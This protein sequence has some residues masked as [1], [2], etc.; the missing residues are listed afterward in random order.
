MLALLSFN[1]AEFHI[2]VISAT[3]RISFSSAPLGEDHKIYFE[4]SVQC[5]R[6]FSLT[7]HISW[8]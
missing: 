2:T 5:Q 3:S 6:N 8:I 1:D 7:L 4:N